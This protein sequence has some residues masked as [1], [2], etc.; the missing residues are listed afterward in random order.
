MKINKNYNK[1][2][3]AVINKGKVYSNQKRNA[4]R[5]QIPSYTFRHEMHKG[6]PLI[7]TREVDYNNVFSELLWFLRGDSHTRFLKENT[8]TRYDKTRKKQIKRTFRKGAR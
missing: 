4:K 1:I 3:K 2:L 8:I 6:F 5:V 7:S